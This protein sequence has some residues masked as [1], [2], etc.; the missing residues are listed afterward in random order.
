[1]KIKEVK[2]VMRILEIKCEDEDGKEFGVIVDESIDETGISW[3][4][5][6][7]S[8]HSYVPVEVE[9]AVIEAIKQKYGKEKLVDVIEEK[10]SDEPAAYLD[11]KGIYVLDE[12]GNKIRS[13]IRDKEV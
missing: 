12:G 10:T 1:M 7:G 2:Q 13:I 11:E 5:V 6:Y 4:V 9:E 3:E 8:D